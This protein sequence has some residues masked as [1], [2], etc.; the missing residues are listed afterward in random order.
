MQVREQRS[1]DR[2]RCHHQIFGFRKN[3]KPNDRRGEGRAKR[4][5]A[6]HGNFEQGEHEFARDRDAQ[7]KQHTQAQTE[8]AALVRI[9]MVSACFDSGRFDRCVERK[10][11]AHRYQDQRHRSV[12]R[13]ESP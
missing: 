7:C 4:A 6:R 8:G 5:E 12:D 13:H 1:R 2:V 10:D 11:R 3:R 9:A